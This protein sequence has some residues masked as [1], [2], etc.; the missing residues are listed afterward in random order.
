MARL[1]GRE[2]T[3][4]L[5]CWN[6]TKGFADPVNGTEYRISIPKEG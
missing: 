5:D 6:A 1:A 4:V 3:D 2:G